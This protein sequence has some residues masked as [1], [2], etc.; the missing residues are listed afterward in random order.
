MSKKETI[1]KQFT[2]NSAPLRVCPTECHYFYTSKVKDSNGFEV[3]LCSGK[4]NGNLNCLL[5]EITDKPKN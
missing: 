3:R 1:P 4:E 2:N 5:P